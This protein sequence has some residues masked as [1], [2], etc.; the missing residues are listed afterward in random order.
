M[1]T[2]AELQQYMRNVGLMSQMNHARRGTVGPQPRWPGRGF[3]LFTT[4][5]TK[6]TKGEESDWFRQIRTGEPGADGLLAKG[7]LHGT[8]REAKLRRRWRAH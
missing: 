4:K 8:I 3:G 1:R 2:E 6:D 7:G 5:L